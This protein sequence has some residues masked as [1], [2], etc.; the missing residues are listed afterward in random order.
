ML[1]RR[2][3]DGLDHPGLCDGRRRFDSGR[4][5][6]RKDAMSEDYNGPDVKIG[7][8]GCFSMCCLAAFIFWMCSGF[9][10]CHN[11]GGWFDE[12]VKVEIRH[13]GKQ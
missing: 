11:I 4:P 3:A 10:G 1:R 8:F 7:G 2:D 12:P 9:V 6:E 13:E 5:H